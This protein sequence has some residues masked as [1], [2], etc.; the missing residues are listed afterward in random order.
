VKGL[1]TA[2]LTL[3]PERCHTSPTFRTSDLSASKHLPPE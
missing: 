2:G 1:L 3:L